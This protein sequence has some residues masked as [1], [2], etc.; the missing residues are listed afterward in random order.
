MRLLDRVTNKVLTLFF[1]LFEPKP[2]PIEPPTPQ[3]VAKRFRQL[4]IDHGVEETRIPRIFPKVSLEDLQ[5]DNLLIKK[6]TPE[7]INEVAEL[8]KVRSE[9]LEGVDDTIYYHQSC[10][11]RPDKFFEFLKTIK[12]DEMGFPFRVITPVEKF[13]YKDGTRQPFSILFVEKI[14]ELGD[15]DIHRYYLDAGWA[16]DHWTCRIQLKAMALL[17]WKH[18]KHPITLY[19]VPRDI[20]S[21]I[22]NLQKIPYPYLT[23]ALISNPSV[24]DYI[25]NSEFS[26]VAKE[27][28][29]LPEV[30]K[31]IEEYKL[32]DLL[33][34]DLDAVVVKSESHVDDD[35]SLQQKASRARHEPISQLK[36]ECVH[37]WLANQKFSNNEAARRFYQA[38]AAENKRLLSESN[39]EITLSKA[40]SEFKRRDALAENNKL[41]NWL[42]GFNPEIS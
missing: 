19:T 27:F 22:E 11:K 12:F 18:I 30:Y 31:Y 4:F 25:S 21:E 24:E 8:F 34:N 28:E 14:A 13:D 1:N 9:W 23:G 20:Y 36:R 6:L 38:L 3:L 10:Y 33:I 35:L 26:C 7:I 41:P 32:S 29:E 17:Y 2:K 15:E 39:A 5:S 37:F 16:W 40:I 42:I